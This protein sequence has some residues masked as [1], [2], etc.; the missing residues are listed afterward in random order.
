MA[1][2]GFVTLEGPDGAG[3]S[4]QAERIAARL[5]EHRLAVLVTREPGGT[6]LGEQIRRLLL[7]STVEARD[8]LADALLFNA[9]RRQLVE[10]VI[11]P[12]L[13][14][15]EWV[16]CDRFADSTLAYQGFGAGVPLAQLEALAQIAMGGLRPDRTV[17]F[18]LP[19][20]VGLRRRAGGAV[21]DLT[22]FESADQHDLAFHERVRRG[23][24]ALAAED[25]ERWRVIDASRAPDAVA[26]DVWAA[27]ADLLGNAGAR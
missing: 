4:S 22:R 14:R 6:A 23:Y 19:P 12:A 18:D 20:E 26:A 2:G 9:A 1:S 27:I 13:E 17:L 25:R 21:S 7:E 15:G 5:R 11:R 24:L 8:P 3:K 16:V 10:E